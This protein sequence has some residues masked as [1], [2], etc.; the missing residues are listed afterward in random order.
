MTPTLPDALEQQ[1]QANVRLEERAERFAVALREI[2]DF[3]QREWLDPEF[4]PVR[5][6]QMKAREA[7]LHG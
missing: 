6:L 7:L 2:A 5:Y 3:D 1:I 4:D